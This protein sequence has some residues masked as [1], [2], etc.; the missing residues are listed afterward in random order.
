[1]TRCHFSIASYGFSIGLCLIA[2]NTTAQNKALTY[3]VP[4]A[5]IKFDLPNESWK[6]NQKEE[7][8]FHLFK[9]EPIEDDAGLKIIPN[10]AIVIEDVEPGLDVVT[11]SVLKRTKVSFEVVE[12]FTHEKGTIDFINAIGYRGKYKDQGGLDHSIIMLYAINE[13]KGIQFI[14]DTTTSIEE[15]MRAEFD[16]VLKSIRK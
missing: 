7:G 12:V 16:H 3:D 14:F 15:T 10:L 9:R 11:Y 5:K 8:K 6:L 2:L 4:E 1:M 13:G